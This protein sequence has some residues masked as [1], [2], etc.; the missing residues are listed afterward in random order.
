M[1]TSSLRLRDP[2]GSYRCRQPPD[3][4]GR[5][6]SGFAATIDGV[7]TSFQV[8]GFKSF[9]DLDLPLGAVNVFIGANGSGKSNLLEAIGLAS[10]AVSGS[11]EPESLRYRGVRVGAPALYKTAFKG[12]T[13]I[14]RIITL[15][16]RT[17]RALYRVG[18]DNPIYQPTPKWKVTTETLESE[19]RT[20]LS[21]SPRG[22]RLFDVNG[23]PSK[24]ETV[25]DQTAAR[26]A[27]ASRPDADG[28]RSLLDALENY[29]IFTPYT[30]M[31]RRVA[32]DTVERPPL[33]LS[34]GGLAE[35]VAALIDR[36]KGTFGP[37]DLDDVWRMIEW[38][39]DLIN[40]PDA[41]SSPQAAPTAA[42]RRQ[43]IFFHDRFMVDR[44]NFLTAYDASEGALYVLFLLALIAHP[45]S[46]TL[47]AVDNF[48]QALHP[49][50]VKNLIQLVVGE[51]VKSKTLLLS[52][53][54]PLVLDGI[55]IR[56]DR[57]RLFAVDRQKT[58]QSRV[59]RIELSEALDQLSKSEGLTLSRLWLMGRLGGVP[60]SL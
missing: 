52:T 8:Q 60:R 47:L 13:S 28:A 16:A 3:E 34:G 46:P 42:Q 38:A 10:A 43:H 37:F 32:T 59:T 45:D 15:T 27:I 21:R 54:N 35:A 7:L 17:E 1:S 36:R 48:D 26:L 19:N 30:P 14:R 2:G 44:R 9:P 18:L 33:G 11:V 24:L 53:H 49:Q 40:I 6:S 57:V 20:I 12:S 58:G 31:L 4:L 39:D 51:S 56:N 23:A 41:P 55:D 29:A 50:L 22:T 25:T 5:P